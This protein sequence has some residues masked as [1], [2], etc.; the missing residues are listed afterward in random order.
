V[1][2]AGASAHITQTPLLGKNVPNDVDPLPVP[3]LLRSTDPGPTIQAERGPSMRAE[4][5]KHPVNSIRQ[6]Y[7]AVGQTLHWADLGRQH[8]S[9]ISHE[10]PVSLALHVQGNCS[11]MSLG[12][13]RD[14]ERL[15]MNIQ[16]AVECVR[17]G[18]G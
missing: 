3:S 6:E 17:R 16:S 7:L 10:G 2:Q 13:I 1:R 12:H 14:G 15:F 18:H 4:C 9:N 8:P 5:V 11:I